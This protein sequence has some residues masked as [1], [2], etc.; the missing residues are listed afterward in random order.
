MKTWCKSLDGSYLILFS[1]SI[2][3]PRGLS[4]LYSLQLSCIVVSAV[5]HAPNALC[6]PF[7][8]FLSPL[9]CPVHHIDQ[10]KKMRDKIFPNLEFLHLYFSVGPGC[11]YVKVLAHSNPCWMNV[12]SY[13]D[14]NC[15]DRSW[16]VP[17]RSPRRWHY[18]VLLPLNCIC[19]VT[20]CKHLTSA[21]SLKLR[22][23]SFRFCSQMY[24]FTRTSL[25]VHTMVQANG[26]S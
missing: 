25:A 17:C 10:P 4:I 7:Y 6:F 3:R 18:H 22:A 9:F 15:Y 2:T 16:K 24:A 8:H 5:R 23:N 19:A 1:S 11:E 14:F 12:S 26:A 13:S 21:N 20:A